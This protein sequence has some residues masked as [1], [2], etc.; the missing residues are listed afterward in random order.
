M[1]ELIQIRKSFGGMVV[2]DKVDAEVPD[3]EI[4]SILGPSECGKMTL[5]RIILGME[6]ADEGQILFQ[7]RDLTKVP[8]EDRG[9]QVMFRDCPFFPNMNVYKNIVYGLRNRPGISSREEVERLIDLL[10]LRR[11]LKS[12][13]GAL[14]A[15][16]KERTA[17]ARLLVMKP[18][19]LLL[20]DPFED[21][22]DEERGKVTEVLRGIL[23]KYCITAV[24]TVRDSEKALMVSDKIL[25]LNRGRVAQYGTP[26]EILFRPETPFIKEFVWNHL[27]N[28]RNNISSLL[29]NGARGGTSAV[30]GL[31]L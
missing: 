24:M 31:H 21:L 20:E 9:F 26:Q 8:M 18:K 7:G 13:A 12:R 5:M 27:E 4:V 10:G 2:L 11:I 1:L 28:K 3:G 30:Q 15:G 19:L 16:E 22:E 17:L 6:E 23:G 14:T 25:I 29:Q